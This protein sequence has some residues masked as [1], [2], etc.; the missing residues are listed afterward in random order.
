MAQA[1]RMQGQAAENQQRIFESASGLVGMMGTA[2]RGQRVLELAEAKKCDWLSGDPLSTP[3]A[4]AEP[5]AE[6]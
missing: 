6:R 4:T 1:A 3:D 2:Q 5:S